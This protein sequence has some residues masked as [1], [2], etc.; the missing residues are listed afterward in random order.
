MAAC[1]QLEARAIL[2]GNTASGCSYQTSLMILERI[3]LEINQS[4]IKS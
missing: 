1:G 2:Q 4:R 3:S